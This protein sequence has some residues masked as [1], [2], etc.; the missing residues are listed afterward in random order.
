MVFIPEEGEQLTNVEVRQHT[1]TP[2][3]AELHLLFYTEGSLSSPEIRGRLMGPTCQYSSTIEIA[4]SIKPID[5][6][7][8]SSATLAGKVII[9]EPSLWDPATPFLYSGPIELWDGDKRLARGTL[10]HG[11]RSVQ[12]TPKGLRWNGKPFHLRGIEGIGFEKL[13]ESEVARLRDNGINAVVPGYGDGDIELLSLADKVGF[14]VLLQ[15]KDFAEFHSLLPLA[16]HPSVLGW[17]GHHIGLEDIDSRNTIRQVVTAHNQL[18]GI[19][20]DERE[21]PRD[22]SGIAF[23]LAAAE[24]GPDLSMQT[25]LPTLLYGPAIPD[26]FPEDESILGYIEM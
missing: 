6:P 10:T 5:V 15:F 25:R 26:N 13:T 3:N 12:L 4:Y 18:L 2:T 7:E 11:L 16:L 19:F 9:P 21:P 14:V 1:L 17:V 8:W 22:I 23:Q 20:I 24:A